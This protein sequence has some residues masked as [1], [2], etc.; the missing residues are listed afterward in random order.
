MLISGLVGF[1]HRLL[2]A[3]CIGHAACAFTLNRAT[4][5]PRCKAPV[6]TRSV[7][8]VTMTLCGQGIAVNVAYGESWP[9]TVARADPEFHPFA[10]CY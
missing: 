1:L 6:C 8:V 9:F 10:C 5:T 7:L 3:S 2:N 4:L